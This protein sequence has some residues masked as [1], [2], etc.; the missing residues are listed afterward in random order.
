MKKVLLFFVLIFSGTIIF[1]QTNSPLPKAPENPNAPVISFE[2]TLFDYGTIE[3]NSDGTH[4][5]NYTNTGKEPLVFSTVRSSCGCTVPEWSKEPLLSKKQ[6]K[7]SVK[8][9]TK[10]L[11]SF[12]KTISI[13]SNAKEPMTVLRITGEVVPKSTDVS[14][15]KLRE[16]K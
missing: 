12:N 11:G 2:E 3:Q 13:Y 10:R 4:D 5:F 8:Y 9:D 14:G 16:I 15:D 7:I 6:G 1:A